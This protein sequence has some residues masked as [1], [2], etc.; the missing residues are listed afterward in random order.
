MFLPLRPV[1]P[2][3]QYRASQLLRVQERQDRSPQVILFGPCVRSFSG[4]DFYRN[5]MMRERVPRSQLFLLLPL[6]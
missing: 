5:L 2:Q 1:I 4:S 3:E 6:W